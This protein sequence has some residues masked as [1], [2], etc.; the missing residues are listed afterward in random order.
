S[1]ALGGLQA[2]VETRSLDL[3][4]LTRLNAWR[5]VLGKWISLI[6][7]ATLLLIAMLPYLVLRY[8]TDNADILADF[9]YCLAMLGTRTVL[10]DA[11]LWASGI[12]KLMRVVMVILLVFGVQ[13]ISGFVGTRFFGGRPVL[14][15]SSVG[16]AMA[17]SP[18]EIINAA[19]V[20]AF[21]L[22]SA[23]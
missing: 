10:T 14:G 7:Q 18:F 2:E 21:F 9:G 11:G 12:A 20:T 4:M 3:L 6:V 23:V 15:G 19:L 5:I 8:F 1:R 13:A 16:F 17:D 22:V